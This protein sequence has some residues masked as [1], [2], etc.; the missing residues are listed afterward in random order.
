MGK[1]E[2][3]ARVWANS[4]ANPEFK[5]AFVNLRIPLVAANKAEDVADDF[6]QHFEDLKDDLQERAEDV[7]DDVEKL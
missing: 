5:K 3:S 1:L 2:P 7:K 6:E 4:D